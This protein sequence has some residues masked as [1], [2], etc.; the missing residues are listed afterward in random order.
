MTKVKINKKKRLICITGLENAD[1]AIVKAL[2]KAT[3]GK[4]GLPYSLYPHH[5]TKDDEIRI[6]KKKNGL[7]SSVKFLL[8]GKFYKAKKNEWSYD[9]EKDRLEFSG[10]NLEGSLP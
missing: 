1:R 4:K 10:E 8:G 2:K 9:Q 3:K 7:I 6:K 5:V